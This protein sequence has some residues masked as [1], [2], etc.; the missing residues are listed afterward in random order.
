MQ[1]SN[2]TKLFASLDIKYDISTDAQKQNENYIK[3]INTSC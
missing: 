3:K 2:I 1:V